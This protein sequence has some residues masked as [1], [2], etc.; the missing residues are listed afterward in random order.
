MF[1]RFQALRRKPK[2]QTASSAESVELPMPQENPNYGSIETVTEIVEDDETPDPMATE[3]RDL[4]LVE[5]EQVKNTFY[6][7]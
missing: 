5:K 6:P 2:E 7:H 4:L 1:K 3:H